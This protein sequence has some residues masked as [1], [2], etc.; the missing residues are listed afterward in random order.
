MQTP[1]SVVSD[2]PTNGTG[3]LTARQEKKTMLSRRRLVTA[4]LLGAPAVLAARVRAERLGQQPND[5]IAALERR[6]GGRLGVAI[7][8]TAGGQK[9][10][11]H[12]GDE[13]FLM[14]S[15][16]KLV[17]AALVLARVDRGEESLSRRI[18]YPRSA[19]VTY[20]PFTEKHAGGDGLTLARLCEAALTLSDNTAAN[21]LLDSFGGPPQWT[22]FARSLGDQVSRLDRR[23]PELNYG[24]AGDP[25][26]TTSPMAMLGT[27]RKLL[28]GRTLSAGS[29]EQLLTWLIACQTGSQR[30]RAGLPSSW[31]AGDKTGS[32]GRN[33]ANDIAIFLPPRREPILV[34]AYYAESAASPDERNSVLADVGRLAANL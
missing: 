7:L 25:R 2:D 28:I 5:A 29:R 34:T 33:G 10:I 27:M 6:H 21:L 23:E 17:S 30:L 32:G 12:R 14:C 9:A 24:D 31:R 20:S 18:V 22:A 16:H 15:T 19:V 13:R 3:R 11:V 1:A 26:D 4:A 8:D